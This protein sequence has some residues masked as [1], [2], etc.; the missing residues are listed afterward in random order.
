MATNSTVRIL[1]ASCQASTT[2]SFNE[3]KYVFHAC[4]PV[5]DFLDE[6]I[7]LQMFISDGFDCWVGF[8]TAS[9]LQCWKS[10]LCVYD[11]RLVWL[12]LQSAIERRDIDIQFEQLIAT[13]LIFRSP[14][15]S[16]ADSSFIRLALFRRS[17]GLATLL[18]SVVSAHDKL[19]ARVSREGEVLVNEV[20]MAATVQP[21]SELDRSHMSLVNPNTRKRKQATG[22]TFRAKKTA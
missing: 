19:S 7:Y 22:F 9:V 4:L 3:R 17:N 12:Y 2:L 5:D 20:R 21:R 11:D 18:F 14:S 15:T 13:H 1:A 10:S 8:V 6:P 16:P